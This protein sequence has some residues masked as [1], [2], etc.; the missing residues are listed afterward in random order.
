[1]RLYLVRHGSARPKSEDPDRHLSDEGIRQVRK[2]AA[3]LSPLG[4][5]VSAIWHSGKT[6]AAETAE[7]IAEAV[8]AGG[9]VVEHEG[10]APKDAVAPVARQAARAG[11]DLAIVGHLP[12]LGRIA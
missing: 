9:G 4:I 1:M 11:R 8:K 5:R 2:V 7:I 3:F 10:L 6:R 12:F